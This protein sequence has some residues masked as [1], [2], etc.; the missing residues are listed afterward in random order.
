MSIL[1]SSAQDTVLLIEQETVGAPESTSV[2]WRDDQPT[3]SP[4]LDGLAGALQARGV[5]VVRPTSLQNVSKVIRQPNPSDTNAINLARVLGADIALVGKLVVYPLENL[6]PLAL[7]QTSYV[8]SLRRVVSEN[9]RITS[10]PIP[11]ISLTVIDGDAPEQRAG[12]GLG[13]ALRLPTQQSGKIEVGVSGGVTLL[14][15]KAAGLSA[16]E[17]VRGALNRDPNKSFEVTWVS[18]DHFALASP[19]VTSVEA[20]RQ[21]CQSELSNL[22]G[23]KVGIPDS[24]TA[25][26]TLTLELAPT[27]TF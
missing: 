27:P 13:R 11:D 26:N 22:S 5:Q 14:I 15:P 8:L 9:G 24:S 3:W 20:L 7:R 16:M 12:A 6:G 21:V 18:A 17:A 25:Q 4:E 23:W 1:A 2:W 19:S 10:Q